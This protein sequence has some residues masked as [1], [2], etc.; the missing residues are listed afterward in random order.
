M[1]RNNTLNLSSEYDEFLSAKDEVVPRRLTESVHIHIR[2]D[3]RPSPFKVFSKVLFTQMMVGAGTLTFCPQFGLSLTSMMELNHFFMRYGHTF[4]TLACGA[5][6]VSF[7]L[8]IASLMLR[9][10]EVR[11]LKR[12]SVL[13]L[14]VLSTLSLGFFIALGAEIVFT[15]ALVWMLGA[16]LGGALSLELGWLLRKQYVMRAA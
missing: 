11:V 13:Q 9:P 4:C 7:S 10:E 1:E 15:L 14:T 6:F 16:I 2:T 5:I 12:N 8:T 3:L